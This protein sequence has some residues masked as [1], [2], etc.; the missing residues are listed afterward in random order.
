MNSTRIAGV[1]YTPIS[2]VM[3]V[4]GM[5][6]QQ[7]SAHTKCTLGLFIRLKNKGV[8]I[9]FSNLV[10]ILQHFQVIQAEKET[11]LLASVLTSCY[12]SMP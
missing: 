9:C 11:K 10:I 2:V 1:F 8:V 6:T 12:I 5:R 7:T 3:N 4:N